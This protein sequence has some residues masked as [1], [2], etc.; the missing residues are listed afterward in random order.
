MMQSR[1]SFIFVADNPKHMGGGE[2]GNN[3]DFYSIML[4]SSVSKHNIGED[5]T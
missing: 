2:T 4:L 3:R 1:G 5:P